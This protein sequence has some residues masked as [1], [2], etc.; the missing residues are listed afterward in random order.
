MPLGF[1]T[2]DLKT[3]TGRQ[4]LG[5]LGTCPS[6]LPPP[7]HPRGA[8]HVPVPGAS[9]D[10]PRAPRPAS[11]RDVTRG[12]GVQPG[13]GHGECPS[14]VCYPMAEPCR[15]LST[16]TVRHDGERGLSPSWLMRGRGHRAGTSGSLSQAGR[17]A[18]SSG[19][20]GVLSS[21]HRLWG[22]VRLETCLLPRPRITKILPERKSLPGLSGR[23]RNITFQNLLKTLTLLL[24][25]D[26]QRQEPEARG[27]GCE[28]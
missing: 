5:P 12:L 2:P 23:A 10:R 3:P 6:P 19:P 7:R 17:M 21:G 28:C 27:P 8:T 4:R 1:R 9:A 22:P 20:E 18:S 13:P 15:S 25:Q 11:R 24:V 16:G 26:K 14:C